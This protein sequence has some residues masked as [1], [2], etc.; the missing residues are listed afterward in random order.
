MAAEQRLAPDSPSC[1]ECRR[2]YHIHVSGG[3]SSST[4]R[5]TGSPHLAEDLGFS[6]DLRIQS[7][8]N[9]EEMTHGREPV[10]PDQLSSG[11]R[12]TALRKAAKPGL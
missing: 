11:A 6:Q 1:R 2:Q 9:D 12:F 4:S 7:R 3:A 5:V 10:V 8:G